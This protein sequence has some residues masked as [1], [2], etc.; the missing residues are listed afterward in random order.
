MAEDDEGGLI[1][2]AEFAKH[3]KMNQNALYKYIRRHSLG[4]A[5]GVYHFGR[6]LRID[7]KVFLHANHRHH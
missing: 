7:P 1:S 5:S 2:V 3:V 6:T 4:K